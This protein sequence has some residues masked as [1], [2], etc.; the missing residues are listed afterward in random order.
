MYVLKDAVRPV[1][2]K[3]M[4]PLQPAHGLPCNPSPHKLSFP[5]FPLLLGITSILTLPVPG[6][7]AQL[8]MSLGGEVPTQSALGSKTIRQ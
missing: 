7:A 1:G 2:Q 5:L 8:Q 3:N 6:F 4:A